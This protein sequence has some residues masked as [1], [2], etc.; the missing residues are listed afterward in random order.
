MPGRQ[1]WR[2]TCSSDDQRT[3]SSL[4]KKKGTAEA[5]SLQHIRAHFFFKKKKTIERT[6]GQTVARFPSQR[7]VLTEEQSVQRQM[8]WWS[9]LTPSHLRVRRLAGSDWHSKKCVKRTQ[10]RSSPYCAHLLHTA[11]KPLALLDTKRRMPKWQLNATHA[12]S[13]SS[14]K[15]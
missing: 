9:H 8:T 2:Y 11:T 5:Q 4:S 1:T 6:A 7:S 15:R 10:Q 12:S 13:P 14:R 3:D